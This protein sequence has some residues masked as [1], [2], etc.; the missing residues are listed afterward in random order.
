MKPL[1]SNVNPMSEKIILID[2]EK[3]IA[4]DTKLAQCFNTYFLN[5]TDSL[6]LSVPDNP[7][8]NDRLN[9]NEMVTNAIKKYK[10]HPSIK[11]IKTSMR[12]DE[13][14]RFSHVHPGYVKDEIEALD[15]KKSNSGDIPVKIINI[16]KA[17]WSH[18]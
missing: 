5:I 10:N 9:L 16:V 13:K 4:E 18:F 14:F 17:L 7:D 11:A 2:G 8:N 12:Q 15:P 3:I 6:G 1:F